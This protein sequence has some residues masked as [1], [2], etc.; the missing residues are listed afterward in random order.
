[1]VFHPPATADRGDWPPFVVTESKALGKDVAVALVKF[2]QEAAPG[3]ALATTKQT[4]GATVVSDASQQETVGPVSA[5]HDAKFAQVITQQAVGLGF[6]NRIAQV[7]T[8]QYPVAVTDIRI[9]FLG[10]PAL[11]VFDD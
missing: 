1:M 5:E 7:L 3:N 8:R 6:R 4:G 2:T 10:V 9:V 11:I